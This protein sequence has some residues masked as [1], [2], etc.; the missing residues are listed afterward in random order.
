ML[1]AFCRLSSV[2]S[3]RKVKPL[4]QHNTQHTQN[5]G[6]QSILVEHMTGT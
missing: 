5:V 1:T 4:Q 3:H 6:Q 2:F